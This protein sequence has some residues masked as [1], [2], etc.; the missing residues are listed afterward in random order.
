[1]CHCIGI[2]L[3]GQTY[4]QYPLLSSLSSPL[5]ITFYF[6]VFSLGAVSLRMDTVRVHSSAESSTV[7]LQGVSL[8]AIHAVTEN[9]E[10][11]C[12][13]S[14]TPN[15]VLKLTKIAFSYIITTHTLQVIRSPPVLFLWTE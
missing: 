5:T 10:S 11:C 3:W 2:I 4:T 6:L 7:S 14:Q 12:P 9:M 15:P 13:A 8:S 1:M